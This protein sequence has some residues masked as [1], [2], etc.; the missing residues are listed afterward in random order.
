MRGAKRGATAESGALCTRIAKKCPAAALVIFARIRAASNPHLSA[1]LAVMRAGIEAINPHRDKTG[2]EANT[3]GYVYRQLDI[4]A[5]WSEHLRLVAQC[6]GSRRDGFVQ[7]TGMAA[8][9]KWPAAAPA[10]AAGDANAR[11]LHPQSTVMLKKTADP[12][13]QHV[14]PCSSPTSVQVTRNCELDPGRR[15]PAKRQ[16][17]SRIHVREVH[18]RTAHCGSA[19][20]APRRWRPNPRRQLCSRN[21]APLPRR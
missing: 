14:S 1:G 13:K 15:R 16:T 10:I 21:T 11:W 18:A 3:R 5:G 9:R 7:D 6:G 4:A 12:T 2:I 17:G 19:S 8:C 20:R